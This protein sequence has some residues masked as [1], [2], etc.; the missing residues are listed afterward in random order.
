ML[1]KSNDGEAT[2]NF[3]TRFS[4]AAV[5]VQRCDEGLVTGHRINSYEISFIRN[6]FA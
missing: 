2:V 4:S 3:T 1:N 5:K 6:F